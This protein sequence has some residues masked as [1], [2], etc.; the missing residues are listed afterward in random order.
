MQKTMTKKADRSAVRLNKIRTFFSKPQ[1]TILVIMA[2]LCTL[3]T[4]APIIAIVEDT[5]KVHIGTIDHH[6]SGK[7]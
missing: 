5:L 6:L 4:F 2:V 1:N 3:T 7:P